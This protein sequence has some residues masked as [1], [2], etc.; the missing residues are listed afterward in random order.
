MLR[1]RLLALVSATLAGPIAAQGPNQA[2]PPAG[3]D[4]AGMDRTVQ[5]G[6]GFWE[7]A[8]GTWLKRTEIP[9][10]RSSWGPGEVL[11]E[12]TDRRT[13]DLIQEIAKSDAP[14][15]TDRRK[16]RVYY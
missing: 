11:S 12:L 9:A 2:K 10:D 16:I 15:G 1:L 3:L 8:N 6:D 4:L 5:P 14:A 13:A 7:Y